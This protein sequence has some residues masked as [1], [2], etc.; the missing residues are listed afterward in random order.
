MHAPGDKSFQMAKCRDHI[1]LFKVK[2]VAA[3]GPQ[4]YDIFGLKS[5]SLHCSFDI[6]S[7]GTKT[8]LAIYKAA[9]YENDDV[10]LID[11]LKMLRS[12]G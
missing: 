9:S 10:K 2:A 6:M 7:S 1:N 11:I 4:F 12:W 5:L 3:L 8:K